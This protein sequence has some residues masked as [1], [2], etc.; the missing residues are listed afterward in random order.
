MKGDFGSIVRETVILTG[1]RGKECETSR[2]PDHLRMGRRV[3]ASL[4]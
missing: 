4:G 1:E 2:H 3:L